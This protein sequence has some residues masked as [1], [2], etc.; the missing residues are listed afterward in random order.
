MGRFCEYISTPTTKYSTE[1]KSSIEEKYKVSLLTKANKRKHQGSRTVGLD[2]NIS[3]MHMK[4]HGALQT[5]MLDKDW[6]GYLLA[7]REK[8]GSNKPCILRIN[9]VV[10]LSSLRNTLKDHETVE[11]EEIIEVRGP[12]LSFESNSIDAPQIHS[13][14]QFGEVSPFKVGTL[15]TSETEVDCLRHTE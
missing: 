2:C 5:D 3:A 6:Q 11:V 4:T 14:I 1:G 15:S 10:S 8:T 13:V 12:D 7:V 9:V